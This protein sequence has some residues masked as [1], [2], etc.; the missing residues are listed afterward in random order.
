MPAFDTP[1]PIAAT[2]EMAAGHLYI[3]A[4][5]RA[6]TVVEVRPTDESSEADANAARQTTV[7]YADGR[8]TVT[9]YKNRLRSLVGRGPSIDVTV[10]LPAG[11][12]VDADS[13]SEIRTEGPLG[14]CTFAT[15]A[16]ALRIDRTGRLRARTAAGEVTLGRADGPAEVTSSTGRIRVGE[17]DGTAVLKT[18]S[19]DIGV[20]EV[21]GEARLKTAHG[22]ITVGRALAGLSAKTAFGAV[23]V[24]E[25]VRGSVVLETRFG[26][27]EIGVRQGTAAWLD[28][29]SQ[30]GSV[31]SDLETAEGP[32]S[33]EETVEVR[34]RTGFGDIVIRRS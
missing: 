27:V 28:V 22:D 33:A 4:G 1:E 15:A 14:D 6:D 2:I 29:A 23:R 24:G 10:E 21:T 5:D 18:S 19:G 11:S 8:L 9:G 7:E 26:E 25:V 34:A 30:N 13:W 16:G 17:V 3:R 20:G 32:G 12:A 31:R